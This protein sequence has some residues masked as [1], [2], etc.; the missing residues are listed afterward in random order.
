MIKIKI[1][2]QNSQ[3]I[4]SNQFS[5]KALVYGTPEYNEYQ[6][7]LTSFP[8]YKT[9]IKGS[10][11]NTHQ[12]HYH[13]LTYDYMRWYITEYEPLETRQSILDELEW[14]LD[15]SRCHSV[16][17]RYPVIKA[18]FL[19]KYPEISKFGMPKS[20]EQQD[21]QEAAAHN[22]SEAIGGAA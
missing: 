5:K 21:E 18:W 17:K 1:D 9:V 14:Q 15:I 19:N 10:K 13:G 16:G 8:G 3:I 20:P 4:L 11:K 22:F 2:T 12:E 6:E 7:V